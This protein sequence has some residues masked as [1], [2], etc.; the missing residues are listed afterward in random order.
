MSGRLRT[1][2]VVRLRPSGLLLM[3][4][5][6][7]VVHQARYTLAY[8]IHADAELAAQGHSY[9]HS[10][11]P[12][13]MLALGIGASM[14]LRRAARAARTGELGAFTRLS[15]TVL[16]AITAT[17]LVAIY[18]VQETLEGLSASGHPAGVAGVFG[19]GGW[20]AVPAAAVVAAGVVALLHAGR[21][22]LRFAAELAPRAVHP[23]A[24]IPRVPLAVA[25]LAAKPLALAAAGRAP[26]VARG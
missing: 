8:G 18:V 16:W 9:L 10:L 21:A 1:L 14:F 23:G 20:Y 26:P 17:G 25:L 24:L 4:A 3:P 22:A 7:L 5:A 6:A 13:T 15:S 19:H 2:S 12:W 11:V